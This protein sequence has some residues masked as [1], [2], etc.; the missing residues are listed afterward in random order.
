[1]AFSYTNKKTAFGAV[2]LVSVK[3]KYYFTLFAMA[4]NAS[5]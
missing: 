1:L 4:L 5:G 2:S 3:S